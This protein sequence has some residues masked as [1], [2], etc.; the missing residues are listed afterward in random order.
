MFQLDS[1]IIHLLVG[2]GRGN[3]CPVEVGT[4]TFA[5]CTGRGLF[6]KPTTHLVISQVTLRFSMPI[7]FLL[8]CF[9]G[10]QKGRSYISTLSVLLEV[11]SKQ[12][13]WMKRSS[14]INSAHSL[15]RN[16]FVTSST[17]RL[18]TTRESSRKSDQSKPQII[19]DSN[20]GQFGS[21]FS[22]IVVD[23]QWLFQS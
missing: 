14:F 13:T 16:D 22:K 20:C 5:K 15:T 8:E 7:S 3:G 19:L 6:G 11:R 9:P 10:D 17:D 12:V 2:R 18:V 23:D 4:I 1:N 21:P